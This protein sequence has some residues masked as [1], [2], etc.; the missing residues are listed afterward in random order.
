MSTGKFVPAEGTKADR[1][2]VVSVIKTQNS[3]GVALVILS[4][5]YALARDPD[6]WIYA[7]KSKEEGNNLTRN[8]CLSGLFYELSMQDGPKNITSKVKLDLVR[9]CGSVVFSEPFRCVYCLL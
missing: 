8:E 6:V 7:K 5:A 1:D 3:V 2:R 4:G 9:R